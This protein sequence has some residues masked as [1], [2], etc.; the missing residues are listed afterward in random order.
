MI[1]LHKEE[2]VMKK[3]VLVLIVL[4]MSAQLFCKS[5]D[6]KENYGTYIPY[7]MYEKVLET[8]SYYDGIV[9]TKSD[10]YYTVLCISEKGTMSNLKFHDSYAPIVIFSFIKKSEKV[11]LIDEKTKIEYIKISDSTD[12]YAAYDEF[13]KQN[14]LK[15]LASKNSNIKVTDSTITIKGK[16]FFVD[17]DQWHYSENLAIILYC[18]TDWQYVGFVNNKWYV[19]QDG[20]ELQKVA[21]YELK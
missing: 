8:S 18:R 17:K 2:N 11:F 16:E 15:K 20:D 13:L 21:A 6:S 12:Y 1:K 14:I 10:S 7:T 9:A 19:L 5:P 4:A 3:N